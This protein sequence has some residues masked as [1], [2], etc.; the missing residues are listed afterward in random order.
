MSTSRYGLPIVPPRE[1]QERGYL[2]EVNRLF[3]HPLGLAL[4]VTLNEADPSLDTLDLLD[5][6]DDPEGFV[7]DD[8][9]DLMAKAQMVQD[10]R[11]TRVQ[12]RTEKFGYPYGIQPVRG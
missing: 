8:E 9:A 10:E 3:F 4:G 5:G 2:Q 6:R 12:A 1:M 7:F 11:A